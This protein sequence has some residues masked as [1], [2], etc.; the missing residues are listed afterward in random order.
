MTH[1]DISQYWQVCIGYSG[2]DDIFVSIGQKLKINS[3]VIRGA[4]VG[5]TP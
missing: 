1:F 2:D 4:A 3:Q 5:T